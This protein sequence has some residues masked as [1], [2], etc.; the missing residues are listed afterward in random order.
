LPAGTLTA[1]FGGEV[2][3]LRGSPLSHHVTGGAV[4]AP[5][6]G[7]G[8]VVLVA[9]GVGDADEVVSVG[10]VAGAAAFAEG[11]AGEAVAGAAVLAEAVSAEVVAGEV[12]LSEAE[13]RS[14]TV[15]ALGRVAGE[16]A[17]Y[18]KP[19]ATKRARA[20]PAASCTRVALRRLGRGPAR[21]SMGRACLWLARPAP[22][23]LLIPP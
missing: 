3:G 2:Y 22:C 8:D 13:P 17:Q 6:P 4:G 14:A 7:G 16:L 15:A 9:V 19:I 21:S 11:T 1:P 10:V 23:H 20:R 12:L 5:P 18:S